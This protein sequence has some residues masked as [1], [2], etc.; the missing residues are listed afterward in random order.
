L[1]RILTHPT[2]PPYQVGQPLHLPCLFVHI[3]VGDYIPK[4]SKDIAD[5]LSDPI[6]WHRKKEQEQ[7]ERDDQLLIMSGDGP[8]PEDECVG[9]TEG[10][11]P[12]CGSPSSVK[13]P[14]ENLRRTAS[15]PLKDG[16]QRTDSA[17]SLALS[18]KEH[19][20]VP[21]VGRLGGEVELV[22]ETAIAILEHKSVKEKQSEVNSKLEQMRKKKRKD[23]GKLQD[24]LLRTPSKPKNP[25]AGFK[26][27][28][29]TPSMDSPSSSPALT[30][31]ERRG[32]CEKKLSCET[33]YLRQERELKEKY[34]DSMFECATKVR[35]CLNI[36]SLL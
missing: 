27:K 13:S 11:P 24:K 14:V 4:E 1:T 5:A 31:E 15:R 2:P 22:P 12:E 21:E 33:Q 19:E 32:Q 18:I 9:G 17:K 26:K 28:F 35:R 25:L 7:K 30:Q 6:L 29:S 10:S 20:V 34:L 23:L 16:P 36:R 3:T 8:E